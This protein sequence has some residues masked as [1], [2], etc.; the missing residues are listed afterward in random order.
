MDVD[1]QKSWFAQEER[2]ADALVHVKLQSASMNLDYCCSEGD[3]LNSP[4]APKSSAKEHRTRSGAESEECKAEGALQGP[5][6]SED[7][8]SRSKLE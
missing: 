7:I 4:N 1:S 5:N 3:G 8:Q 2:V 6:Q